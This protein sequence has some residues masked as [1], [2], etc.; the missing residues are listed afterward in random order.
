ME[1]EG[2]GYEF[3]AKYI[4]GPADGLESCV[5]TLN[6]DIPPRMSYLEVGKL[7]RKRPLGSHIFKQRPARH[8]RIGVYVLEGEA[9]SYDHD[10]DVLVYQF[11]ESMT[12]EEFVKKFG[13]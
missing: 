3:E 10:D 7:P 11:L 6:T 2:F 5:V 9:S 8:S 4:G 13:D 1:F 12:Y